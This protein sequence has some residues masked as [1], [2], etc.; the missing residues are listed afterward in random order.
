MARKIL[1]LSAKRQGGKTTAFW[2]L[3]RAFSE[4]DPNR[5]H[6]ASFVESLKQIVNECFVPAEWP[7]LQMET[8][9]DK[10][11]M[12]PCRL[13]VREVLSTIASEWFRGLWPQCWDN[14][15][16]RQLQE[17]TARNIIVPDVRYFSNVALIQGMG[18]HV[19]RFL[20]APYVDEHETETALDS[21]GLRPGG[22]F[23][24]N[25]GMA[26]PGILETDPGFDAIIDNREMTIPEQNQA[27]LALV[28][29]RQW[30]A[31]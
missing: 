24:G 12:L 30:I 28:R 1:G 5:P 13:T 25:D 23:V 15:L 9:E 2:A 26:R 29:A 4:D 18:G 3:V 31:F 21:M 16:Q 19:I 11:R 7:R 10:A 27:V 20:R 22:L 8:E 6:F 17:S 14:A